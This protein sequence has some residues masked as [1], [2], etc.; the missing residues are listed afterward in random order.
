MT[1]SLKTNKGKFI[2]TLVFSSTLFL[3]Y[4]AFAGIGDGP[5]AF[6]IGPVGAQKIGMMASH[7]NSS[8]NLDGSPAEPSARVQS[9]VVAMQYVRIT[10]IKKK[11][12]G[13]FGYLPYGEVTQTLLDSPREAESSGM[14]DIY[15]GAVI[16]LYNAPALKLKEYIQYKPSFTIALLTK[17]TLP[18]GEYQQDKFANMGN[19][20]WSFRTGGVFSWYFGD[21]LLP[22][23]N[24]SLEFTPSITV[25][26]DNN[27]PYQA[28]T[29]KQ[30]EMYSLETNLTHDFNHMF[31]GSLDALYVI[32][33]ASI[34]D[35]VK[36]DNETEKVALGAS[37]GMF[38]SKGFTMQ[39]NYGKTLKVDSEGYNDYSLRLKISKAF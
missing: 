35:G 23:Q 14:G 37:V 13:L 22:G 39:V 2:F 12:V 34:T 1:K 20:R 29:L 30:K 3:P 21:S 8:F 26:G 36:A 18:T 25:F 31:W 38:I 28:S 16:G 6:Q 27:Q 7:K 11:V 15:L 32:G 4:S 19:N 33:G 17:L 5:R 9:D 24:T 10:Q